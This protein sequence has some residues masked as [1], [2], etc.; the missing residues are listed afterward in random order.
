MT[1]PPAL[2]AE[3]IQGAVNLVLRSGSDAAARSQRKPVPSPETQYD[4]EAQEQRTS[5]SSV[6]GQEDQPEKARRR[7]NERETAGTE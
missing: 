4:R 3:R 5:Y 2:P 1:H 7:A 6:D